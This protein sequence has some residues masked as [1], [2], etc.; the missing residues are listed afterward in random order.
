MLNL[1]EKKT[2]QKPGRVTPA[3][4]YPFFQMRWESVAVRRLRTN[5]TVNPPQLFLFSRRE[6]NEP[7]KHTCASG[8]PGA[9]KNSIRH[10][11]K[12]Q[13]RQLKSHFLTLPLRTLSEWPFPEVHIPQQDRA[14][15]SLLEFLKEENLIALTEIHRARP[16]PQP[17]F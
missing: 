1:T 12:S 16:S 6:D 2:L 13:L 14:I 8:S 4:A 10:C 17:S 11:P 7:N 15:R 5:T 3:H 9:A